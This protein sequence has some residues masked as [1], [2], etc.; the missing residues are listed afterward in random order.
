[1]EWIVCMCACVRARVRTCV[2][3]GR[4]ACLC[5]GTEPLS[6]YI[7]STYHSERPERGR[8]GNP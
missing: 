6:G 7:I 5:S 1:M 3:S 2:P 8:H 4:S